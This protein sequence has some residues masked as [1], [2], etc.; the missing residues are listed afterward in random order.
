MR[1]RIQIDQTDAI[2]ALGQGRSQIDRGG[3]FTHSAFLVQDSNLTHGSGRPLPALNGLRSPAAGP[4]HSGPQA[5]LGGKGAAFAEAALGP[6]RDRGGCIGGSTRRSH[7]P[8]GSSLGTSGPES[9]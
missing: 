7:L 4:A 6:R 3:G 8:E 5:A 1:L 9:R 2:T